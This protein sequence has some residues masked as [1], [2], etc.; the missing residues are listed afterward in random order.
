L[1]P[2]AQEDSESDEF[3]LKSYMQLFQEARASNEDLKDRFLDECK[4]FEDLV[5]ENPDYR[6]KCGTIF[7]YFVVE[8]AGEKRAPKV[9][10]V[11][12]D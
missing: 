1:N 4:P 6:T 11:L 5:P 7:Y 9:T 8:L 3:Q 2:P 12:I 10:S